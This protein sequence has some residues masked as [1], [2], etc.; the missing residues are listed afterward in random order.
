MERP[1]VVDPLEEEEQ[2]IFRQTPV[3]ELKPID[4]QTEDAFSVRCVRHS[5]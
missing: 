4:T 1:E 5:D 3:E 2:P